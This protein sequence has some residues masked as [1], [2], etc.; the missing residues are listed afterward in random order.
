M[1]S[2]STLK[3]NFLIND[4]SCRQLLGP[5]SKCAPQPADG[6]CMLKSCWM[7]NYAASSTTTKCRARFHFHNITRVEIRTQN[8]VTDGGREK[9]S[10]VALTERRKMQMMLGVSFRHHRNSQAPVRWVTFRTSSWLQEEV[11]FAGRDMLH[12]V[13]LANNRW[14]SLSPNGI[15]GKENDYSADLHRDVRMGNNESWRD[16]RQAARDRTIG[17]CAR[18][19]VFISITP[20]AS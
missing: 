2:Y 3:A 14:T 4:V 11:K 9:H 8:L 6:D 13:R 20:R 17:I 1:Y 19:C 16:W 7:T 12:V 10:G 5:K 15:H 18:A